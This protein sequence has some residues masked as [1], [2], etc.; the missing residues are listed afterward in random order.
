M[1]TLQACN[2]KQCLSQICLFVT[3]LYSFS[4]GIFCEKLAA[5]CGNTG[6][7]G[8][9][10]VTGHTYVVTHHSTGND[11]TGELG[12]KLAFMQMPCNNP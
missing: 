5:T 9:V 7:I 12:F 8:S 3:V 1:I 2:K 11:N 10:E 6:T 4:G